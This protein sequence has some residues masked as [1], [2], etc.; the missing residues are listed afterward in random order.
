MSHP[1]ISFL[2]TAYGTE[3]YVGETIDSVLAQTRTDWEL[4]VV[5]NGN[6]EEMARVVGKYTGDS[7]IKLVRQENK[8]VRGGVTAAADVAV[9]RY[10]CTVNSD[11]MLHPDF[12][13]RVGAL[14]DAAPGVDAVGCDAE[15]FPDP[16]DGTPPE[17]YFET[18]GRRS[19]PDPS[20]AVSLAEF[21]DEGVP[22]YI[23]AFRREVWDAFGGYDPATSDV[24]PDVELWLR[25][26]AAGR[27]VRVLPDRLARIRVRPDSLSHDPS[28][29]EDFEDALQRAF[30][31]VCEHSPIGGAAVS[32]APMMRRLRYQRALR[33]AR[34]AL[35]GGDVPGAR[36]AARDAYHHQRTL[37][38]AAVI[39]A[40]QISPQMFRSIHPAKNRAQNALRRARYRITRGRTR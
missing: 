35:L 31:V 28:H 4:I 37:R 13:E 2:T 7:R 16:D 6:S 38:A 30:L 1:F 39:A 21:L 22:L 10:L 14:I 20:R 25:V 12:C 40:L 26:A 17:G 29:V 18:T 8:G 19:V 9:G 15:R 11:D 3:R 24:E 23:G 36:A 34:W 27:D 5:D 33:R 32:A